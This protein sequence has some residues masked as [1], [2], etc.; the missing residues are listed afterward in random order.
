MPATNF[1]PSLSTLLPVESIPDSLGFIKDGVNTIFGHLY[2]KDLQVD[3]SVCGDSACYNLSLI[4]YKRLGIELL[5]ADGLALVLNPDF[6]EGVGNIS[7]FPI[8]LNY[9][10]A[11]LRYIKS[12]NIK[13]F[14]FSP[15][16]FFN[17]ILE[18]TGAN[19]SDLLYEAIMTFI[20]DEDPIQQFV[21][22]FNESY[23]PVTPLV[24]ST[25]TDETL[26]IADIIE[27]L[28]TNG[29]DYDIFELIFDYFVN[30]SE[31][32]QEV[33]DNIENLFLKWLGYFTID[34]I[35]NMLAPQ[36]SVS[37]NNLEVALEFPRPILQPIDPAT[38]EPY[39][40][41][42]IK[43]KLEF[44]VGTLVFSTNVGFE[45]K[46][47]DTFVFQKSEIGNTGIY[48]ELESIKLD[49][50]TDTNIPEADADG[51]PDNFMGI[52]A[53]SVSITLPKKWF[54]DNSGETSTLEIAGSNL[55]I[56]TGGISGTIG[57]YAI[58]SGTIGANDYLWK[59]IGGD[60]GFVK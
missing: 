43:S 39:T 42:N 7:L 59:N 33:L 57:L 1:Y 21:D 55:L 29:N 13:S 11:I 44:N 31:D 20:D 40:D 16:A 58:N 10:W 9:N 37:L 2:Y 34:T 28:Q 19:N 25:D 38:D 3:R 22:D 50:R 15:E 49:L 6:E 32:V 48:V 4:T 36:A 8:S 51:R 56:G 47:T 17:L 14:D 12:F 45:F 53:E 52:Y 5:G 23:S 24:K 54:S 41:D 27:Q 35:K 46:E 18:F 30:D 60:N 26:V